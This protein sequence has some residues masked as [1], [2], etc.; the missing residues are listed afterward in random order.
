[1][2]VVTPCKADWYVNFV[3]ISCIPEARYLAFESKDIEGSYVLMETQFDDKKRAQR[4]ELWKKQGYFVPIGLNFECHMP[5]STYKITS[6]QPAPSERGQCGASPSIT[7]SLSR[8]DKSYLKNVTFGGDCFGGPSI[9][10]VELSDGLQGWDTQQ[11]TVCT[12]SGASHCTFLSETYGAI[13][14]TIPIDQLKV[15]EFATRK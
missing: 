15:S 1:M 7:L 2:L 12:S 5:E 9:Y 13:S 11:M 8:D 10:R 3:H 6:T 14:K 4:F